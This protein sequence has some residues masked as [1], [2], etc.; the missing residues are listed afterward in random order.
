MYG[1]YDEIQKVLRRPFNV[2]THKA[3]FKNY[4]EVCIDEYGAVHY[5]VP[6]HQE[7][8]IGHLINTTYHSRD[9]LNNAVPRE[10]WLDMMTWLTNESHII[11]VWN[12]RYMGQPNEAQMKA[13][14]KLKDEGLYLGEL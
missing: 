3:T 10:Y 9:T 2:T 7:F 11:S 4:L 14:A 12:D 13:L 1:N 5:A 6:S 8:L